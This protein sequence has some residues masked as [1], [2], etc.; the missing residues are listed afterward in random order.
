MERNIDILRKQN[1]PLINGV[2]SC[3][4]DELERL[5]GVKASAHSAIEDPSVG[6]ATF[7]ICLDSLLKC[8]SRVSSL[9]TSIEKLTILVNNGRLPE[10]EEID[11]RLVEKL[12]IQFE[13]DDGEEN[14]KG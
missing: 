14:G 7:D 9:E 10:E 1:N 2:L 12:R 11:T 3:Y 6:R 13:K 5:A 4:M 8:Y